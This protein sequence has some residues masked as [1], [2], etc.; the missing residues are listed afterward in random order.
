MRIF[1]VSDIH[2][3]YQENLRWVEALSDSDYVRDVLVLAGDV[4]HDRGLFS[5]VLEALRRKFRRVFFVPGNHE[6][7]LRSNEPGDSLRKYHDVLDRCRR[8]GVDTGPACMHDGNGG[9]GVWNVPLCSWYVKPEE[10]AAE[11]LFVPK[12][13]EDPGLRMWVDD[14]AVRWPVFDGS[15]TPAAYFLACNQTPP[16]AALRAGPVVSFSHFVPR[17]DLLFPS[18]AE[19]RALGI[20]LRDPQPRFNF[21][22]VAG[23]RGLERHI[24][25]LGSTV[26]V[27]GHQHRNRL[28]RIEGVTYVS[29]CLGYPRERA[30]G[31]ISP[32]LREPLLIRDMEAAPAAS[33]QRIL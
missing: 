5:R 15:R 14:R 30:E 33:G 24:R 1:A 6:L 16:S 21:S 8:L 27:Y 20:P 32:A 3:D 12:Q 23:C 22:R 10:D 9:G 28:R 18:A 13:G 31:R 4:S 19:L 2:A 26:H 11:S 17:T 25:A 29:H 7:W